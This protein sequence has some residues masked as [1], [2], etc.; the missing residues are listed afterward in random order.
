M[1]RQELSIGAGY[2]SLS[3]GT[4]FLFVDK[5]VNSRVLNLQG[6]EMKRF[7]FFIAIW[8]GNWGLFLQA[9]E[10]AQKKDKPFEWKATEPKTYSTA[11]IQRECKKY[12]GEYIGYYSLIFKV[13]K[14]KRRQLVGKELI[15]RLFTKPGLKV[16]SVDGDTVAKLP[17]GEDLSQLPE[18]KL[19]VRGCRDLSGKY[20]I[21]GGSDIYFVERC[22]RRLLPDYE[23]YQEHVKKEGGSRELYELTADEFN[24]LKPGPPIESIMPQ[25]FKRLMENWEDADLIPLS[26]ACQGINGRFVTYYSKLYF[27]EKCFKREVLDAPG[28]MKKLGKRDE[29]F[30]E[31][32]SDQWISLPDGKPWTEKL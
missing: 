9:Q 31:L 27:I 30:I 7:M 5:A 3:I 20:V 6:T 2:V 4:C 23:T 25:V 28:M 10:A 1:P 13:E 17:R 21:Y 15:R 18:D 12:E 14:C 8:M 24:G 32:S 26:E 11:E 22:Q 29:K 16:V 19:Q